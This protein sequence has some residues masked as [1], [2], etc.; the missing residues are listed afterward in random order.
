MPKELQ[1]RSRSR[2]QRSV[3]K[4]LQSP[5]TVSRE[6]KNQPS[7]RWNKPPGVGS[8]RN[9]QLQA[10]WPP[11]LRLLACPYP[12]WPDQRVYRSHEMGQSLTIDFVPLPATATLDNSQHMD[13]SIKPQINICSGRGY[14]AAGWSKVSRLPWTKDLGTHSLWLPLLDSGPQ[15][16]FCSIASNLLARTLRL[17]PGPTGNDYS[18]LCVNEV[19]HAEDLSAPCLHGEEEEGKTFSSQFMVLCLLPTLPPTCWMTLEPN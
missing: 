9:G 3:N 18:S 10:Q 16:H 11:D 17:L 12:E 2:L 1:P 14:T 13:F 15:P 7:R 4:Y 5:L 6:K 8:Q 19:V